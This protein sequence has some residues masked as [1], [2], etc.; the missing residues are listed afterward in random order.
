VATLEQYLDALIA[1]RTKTA[2]E[3]LNPQ[4]PDRTEFRFGYVC[5]VQAGLL[6]A[7]ELLNKQLEEVEDDGN[8][9]RSQRTRR[10]R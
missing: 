1:L 5:G 6:I 2:L 3:S 8:E 4:G 9:Q 7:E 10:T